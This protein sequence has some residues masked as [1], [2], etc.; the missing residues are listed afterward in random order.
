MFD[1]AHESLISNL[2]NAWDT[3]TLGA[4]LQKPFINKS[5]WIDHGVSGSI[6]V[7]K[8]ITLANFV[9]LC[10]PKR[11]LEIG[12]FLGLSSNFFLRL[13]YR[14]NGTVTTIDP[15]I[16][17]RVFERP[18]DFYEKMNSQ[19]MHRVHR[20]DGFWMN[21]MSSRNI[22][23]WSDR[24][25][26]K[27]NEQ[28]EELLKSVPLYTPSYF[29]EMKLFFD[30]VFI[31]GHGAQDLNSVK[32]D[33]KSVIPILKPGACVIFDDVSRDEWPETY[34]AIVDFSKEL[35]KDSSGI[36]LFS[37]DVALFVDKGY[38]EKQQLSMTNLGN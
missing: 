8:A 23:D 33:I 9:D 15:N 6:T 2:N 35:I 24:D 29:K 27:T 1:R 11:F 28:V 31:D 10:R 14:W 37:S 34:Q 7:E 16:R 38:I 17:H 32:R 5:T 26:K 3:N 19:F 22:S 25:P 20:Y 30:M 21:S 18:R 36:V 4:D 13:L 12:S